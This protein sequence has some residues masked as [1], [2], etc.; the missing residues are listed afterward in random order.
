MGY[1]VSRCLFCDR[2]A[3]GVE[4]MMADEYH[5]GVRYHVGCINS[6]AGREWVEQRRR[7]D[8]GYR[9]YLDLMTVGLAHRCPSCGH[10]HL[11]SPKATGMGAGSW[12][13]SCTVCHRH[14]RGLLAYIPEQSPAYQ[15]LEQIRGDFVRGRDL[16]KVDR[17]LAELAHAVD[18]MLPPCDCGG[19]TSVAAR[20][21]C[22]SCHAI[23]S[24]S[25]F[26]IVYEGG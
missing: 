3:D 25:A 15:R 14:R 4:F 10:E 2:L 26:N 13:V 6:D 9:R 18:H 20:P 19:A 23:V 12:E 16:E 11:M 7:Q 8:P 17:E 1:S 22:P 21:L 24:D 5:D